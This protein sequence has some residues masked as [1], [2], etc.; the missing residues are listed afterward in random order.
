MAA[1]VLASSVR[2]GTITCLSPAPPLMQPTPGKKIVVQFYRSVSG[3]RRGLYFVAEHMMGLGYHSE[4]VR[5]PP[6]HTHA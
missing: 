4:A 2:Y 3:G 1:G 5:T 6:H